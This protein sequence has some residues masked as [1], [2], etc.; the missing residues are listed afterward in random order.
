MSKP[1]K[2][3]LHT[4]GAPLTVRVAVGTRSTLVTYRGHFEDMVTAGAITSAMLASLLI[5]LP[6]GNQHTDRR[7]DEFGDLYR[8][9]RLRAGMQFGNVSRWITDQQRALELPGV[10]AA[11][12]PSSADREHAPHGAPRLRLVWSNPAMPRSLP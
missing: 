12:R 10:M 6:G 1:L 8:V 5:R 3:K 2:L 9:A 4:Q 7:R 11:L